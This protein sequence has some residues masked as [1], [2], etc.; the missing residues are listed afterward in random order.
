MKKGSNPPPPPEHM[1]P[2]P[3]PAPPR[4]PLTEKQYCELLQKRATA[5]VTW[6]DQSGVHGK[7][8]EHPNFRTSA[9]LLRLHADGIRCALN[10]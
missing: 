8:M 9:G 4:P 7:M 2:E 5:F 10:E 1:R 3:P 6:W